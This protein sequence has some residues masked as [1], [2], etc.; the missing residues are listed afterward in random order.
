MVPHVAKS[1]D[2]AVCLASSSDLS[3]RVENI[4]VIGGSSIYTVKPTLL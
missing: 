1:L 2:E 4:F 3:E